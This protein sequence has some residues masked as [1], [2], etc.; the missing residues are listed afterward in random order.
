[1]VDEAV[2]LWQSLDASLPVLSG[3]LYLCTLVR[4]PYA[5]HIPLVVSESCEHLPHHI[6][7]FFVAQA[8]AEPFETIRSSI[9]LYR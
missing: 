7:E 5:T 4:F 1:M 9:L 8:C 6:V 3:L 2:M